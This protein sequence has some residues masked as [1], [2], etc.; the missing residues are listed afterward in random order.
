MKIIQANGLE[1]LK[2]L[3]TLYTEK[4]YQGEAQVLYAGQYNRE[5]IVLKTIGSIKL[6]ENVKVTFYAELGCTGQSVYIDMDVNSGGFSFSS[7]RV[8]EI[9]ASMEEGLIDESLLDQVVGGI[10]SCTNAASGASACSENFCGNDFSGASACAGYACGGA[11]CG[12]AACAGNACAADGSGASACAGNACSA[13]AGGAEA[14][15][16][17]A[18]AAAACG[19]DSCAANA[20][21][22]AAC[23]VNACPANTCAGDW[24]L[25]NICPIIPF[26]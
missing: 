24:C 16:A 7:L 18:C 13:D 1:N 20:C 14:C 10:D 4:D 6:E 22:A 17:N 5:Q 21:P 26:I 12:A 11:A 15:A 23:G 2:G 9:K 3:C 19:A 25:I 8:E